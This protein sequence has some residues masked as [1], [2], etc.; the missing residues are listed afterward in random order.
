LNSNELDKAY[1]YCETV[2][3]THAKSFYFAAKFLPKAKRPPIYAIYALCRH[4]DD[5]IDEAVL[6][7]DAESA[8]VLENWKRKLEAIYD[9]R[10]D[11]DVEI[12]PQQSLVFAA[13]RHLLEKYKIRQELPL[14]LMR[15]VRQDTVVKRYETFEELY[16]Y[17]YRVASTVG[18]MAS[19]IFG[20][21]APETLMY[22]EKLGIAMQL[23]NILRD[24]RE[25]AAMG[26][27]Y[28]PQ[29]DLRRFGVT[30]EQ[31]FENRID[32]SFLELMKFQIERARRYYRESEPGIGLLERDTRFTVLLALR[33]YSGILDEIETLDYN[34]FK[35]R[36]HTGK[37][38]KL[39]SIPKVWL[40]ARKI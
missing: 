16:V 25:D 17:C 23:T 36:A 28:L 22:A 2:T 13:W 6:R 9:H 38:Q 29:E 1:E 8:Q 30:E 40:E 21:E 7:S 26:R 31:I 14:D 15:G 32:D 12:D 20:Y 27:I 18:L 19:E 39:A 4:V 33:L 24:I 35:E 10:T 34:V 37:F 5:E 11:T 3:R